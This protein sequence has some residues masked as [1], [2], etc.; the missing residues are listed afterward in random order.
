MEKAN[1][2][3]TAKAR[4]REIIGVLGRYELVRGLSPQKLRRILEDLGPTFVKLGQIMSMRP[5]MIPIEYCEELELLRTDVRPMAYDEL[6]DVLKGEFGEGWHNIFVS[7]D[8][9]P[10]GSASIAQVHKAVL[11]DGGEMAIKVQRP[12]IFETM[13][14]DIRLLHKASGMFR[15]ISRAGKVIDLNAVI[16]E[17]WAVAQQELDFIKEAEHIKEFTDANVGVEY[18]AFPKVEWALTTA[19]VL[20]ME[21]V[22]GIPIN[23]TDTLIREGYDLE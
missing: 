6:L 21:Y 19:K 11:K 2:K 23:D 9:T 12:G 14:Q 18:I 8:P 3:S 15:I 4:L 17:M 1:K 5:D 22:E 16:D 10:I 13:L 20:V 7:V